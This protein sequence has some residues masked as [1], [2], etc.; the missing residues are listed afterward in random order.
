MQIDITAAAIATIISC[1]TSASLTLW[2]NRNN[3][4]N[5]LSEQLDAIL[6][7][8]I[9]Y[10]YLENPKFTNSWNENKDSNNDDYLRYDNYHNLVFNFLSR[11]CIYYKF[12]KSK[13]E[14]HISIKDWIRTHRQCWENPSSPYENTDSYNEKFNQ[15]INSYLK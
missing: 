8:A 5:K 4:K 2:I 11:L 6:K 9:Q 13:I 12:D 15:F 10:P 3:D 1:I 7:I 14:Q